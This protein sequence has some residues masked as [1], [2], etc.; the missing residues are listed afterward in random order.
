MNVPKLRPLG[1]IA[2]F[3]SGG[4]PNRKRE[5][6]YSGSIPWV[7]GADIDADGSIFPRHKI[8]EQA[9]R[10]SATGTASAGDLLLVTRTSVGKVAITPHS[11]CFSQ[12]ITSVRVFPHVLDAR[13]LFHYIRSQER[14]FADRAR[15]ATIKGVTREV[16]QEFNVPI[17]DLAEQ[18]RI[19]Q[20]L[21]HLEALRAKRLTAISLLD[22]LVQSIFVDMFGDPVTNPRGLP[23]VQLTDMGT[24]DRGVSKHRPR[25][26]PRL[27]G[28]K[29]PL[30]QTGDVAR[31]RGYIRSYESTYSDM[32]ISQS[33]LWPAGTLCITIAAN[34][35]KTGILQFDACFPDSVVGF[36]ADPEIVE[37][38]QA[39]LSFLQANLERMAPESAQKNINLATLRGLYIPDPGRSSIQEF[40]KRVQ[41]V[42]KMKSAAT[43]HLAE[44]DA[45]FASLRHRVFEGK[46]W[47]DNSV[48]V[49]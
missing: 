7:T 10:E 20:M 21:D 28:G 17:L 6:F 36:T 38:V 41:A 4:T 11:I 27:L 35:A 46:M 18:E 16:V 19:A 15:G 40:S 47:A 24:L 45:L 25:N 44:L 9:V 32:G 31:S 33:R 2:D 37:Y 30:I 23:Q 8:S 49:A 3:Q 26:D 43:S 5:D 1:E 48:P 34:I 42:V 14:Y 22:G 29:Y 12:D 13:Y 39:W